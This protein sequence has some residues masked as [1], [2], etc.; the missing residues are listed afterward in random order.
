MS[1]VD[2]SPMPKTMEGSRGILKNIA[3]VFVLFLWGFQL[4]LK[5]SVLAALVLNRVD[6][7]QPR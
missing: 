3:E 7:C 1:I 2:V 5:R 4:V 6:A